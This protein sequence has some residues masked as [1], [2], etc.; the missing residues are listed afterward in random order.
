MAAIKIK[1]GTCF[2]LSVTI[3]DEKF[4]D[5]SVIEFL[6]KQNKGGQTLKTAIWRKYGESRDA[7]QDSTS[8]VITVV[9]SREDSYLFKQNE[10]FFMDTRIHYVDVETNPVTDIVQLRMSE[11]L[12]SEG[13]EVS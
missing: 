2:A 4:N 12:F 1:A 8:N 11:T 9:F 13:E 3:D 6:F 5:I 10:I 7:Y